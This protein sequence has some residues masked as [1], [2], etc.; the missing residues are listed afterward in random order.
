MST[1]KK[2]PKIRSA[3]DGSRNPVIYSSDLPS[4]TRQSFKEESDINFIIRQY[5]KSGA[6]T[7]LQK[8]QGQ[9]GDFMDIDYHTAMNAVTMADEMFETVPADIRNRFG[10]DPGAFLEFVSNEDNKAELQKLGLIPS[11][12]MEI[13]NGKSREGPIPDPGTAPSGDE[14]GTAGGD[15]GT[16]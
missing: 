8:F 2:L 6:E 14:P 1:P 4:M 11:D 15:G 10:N 5:L 16:T 9:Y 7:H 13:D 12:G 3:F